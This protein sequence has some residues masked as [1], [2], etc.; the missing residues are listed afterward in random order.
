MSERNF[1]GGPSNDCRD[2]KVWMQSYTAS[3]TSKC[4]QSKTQRYSVSD[5]LCFCPHVQ[6]C[7]DAYVKKQEVNSDGMLAQP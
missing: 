2:I 5:L 1:H 3:M 7:R 6:K 4:F